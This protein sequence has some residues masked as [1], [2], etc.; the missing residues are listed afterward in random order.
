MPTANMSIL[1]LV[2]TVLITHNFF[3]CTRRATV[4]RTGSHCSK[5]HHVPRTWKT[6]SA[7]FRQLSVPDVL[8][9]Q[10]LPSATQTSPR[11][12]PNTFVLRNAKGQR[13][14]ERLD[15][16]AVDYDRVKHLSLCYFHHIL[17]ECRAASRCDHEHGEL[18]HGKREA[19][20]AAARRMPCGQGSACDNRLCIYGHHCG[21]TGEHASRTA[22]FLKAC[23]VLTRRWSPAAWDTKDRRTGGADFSDGRRRDAFEM[24]GR[25]IDTLV[26]IRMLPPSYQGRSGRC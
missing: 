10:R 21:E 2:V 23:M 19:L 24:S 12:L 16:S 26:S 4:L 22:A 7:R 14:D 1:E 25:W 13:V 18:T 11:P 5:G 9:D 6:I 8:R 3:R 17:G 20:R 15:H